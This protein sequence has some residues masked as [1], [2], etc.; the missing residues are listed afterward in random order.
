MQLGFH[1]MTRLGLSEIA[2]A[3]ID[4]LVTLCRHTVSALQINTSAFCMSRSL[5]STFFLIRVFAFAVVVA[6][7]VAL[8][9]VCI[10]TLMS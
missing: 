10:R 9:R 6:V 2:N 4:G 7:V 5:M 3:L 1:T 8:H